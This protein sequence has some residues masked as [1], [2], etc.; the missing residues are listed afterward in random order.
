MT[1]FYMLFIL[2]F[3][4]VLWLITSCGQSTSSKEISSEE[5]IV[6]DFNP[7]SN[8]EQG[9]TLF[10]DYSEAI[11]K[12]F[13]IPSSKQL[14]DGFFHLEFQLKNTGKS[15]QKYFYKIYYQNESYKFP[16]KDESDS[17]RQHP[18]AGEN[19]YGSWEG[20]P[21]KFA[22]TSVIPADGEFHQISNKFRIVGNPRN[23]QRYFDGSRNDRWKRNPRVGE[24]SFMLVVTTAENIEQKKIPDGVQNIGLQSETGFIN[25]FFFFLYGPGKTLKNIVVQHLPE[26]LKVVA[27]PDPGAGIYINPVAY[28][29]E[30]AAN[31]KTS[32]CGQ[33]SAFYW[34]AA[35]EQF[36][37]YVD[38]STKMNNIPVIADIMNGNYSRLDYNWNKRFYRKE[39]LVAIT[40]SVAPRPC[41]TVISDPVEHKITIRNPKSEFGKWQKQNVGIITRHGMTYG[42]WTAK[43]KLTELLNKN[44]MWNG[45]TNA[46]WLIT[47]SQSDWNS[48]RDCTKGGYMANYYGGQQ[49]Q[50]VKNVGYSEIDFEILKTVP[51]CPSWV[52]P[53]AYNQGIDD[54]YNVQNWNVPFPEEI[55]ADDDKIMVSCTNWDMA[56]WQ[57][58]DFHDGCYPIRYDN[59]TFWTHRWDKNYRALTQKTP[60]RDDELFGSPWYYFQIDWQPDKII[61]RIGPSKEKLRVVGYMD[62]KVTSIP[63]NQMLLIITQEFHNTKWWIGS[64]YSQD[65]IPFPKEDY[66]GEIFEVTIE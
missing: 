59:K 50:R 23:E 49:D 2:L 61:W 36:V 66:K 48:R 8:W 13:V 45:L 4:P 27:K 12:G 62:D 25:P 39:E 33:D 51:Y 35:F 5:F 9:Q 34:T 54:Q 26:T 63:N 40:A 10:L 20:E 15:P 32:V 64:A 14:K 60:E 42:K 65:N 31:A 53:P 3:S 58:V 47:Q 28:S 29:K 19:F 7:I 18:N 56:C 24:Y 41:E 1:R 37:H 30:D 22:E 44:N 38:P 6:R 46:I 17:T 57:P 55:L 11:Q 52:L 43:C 21:V 16:E